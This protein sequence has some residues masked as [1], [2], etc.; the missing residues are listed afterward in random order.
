MKRLNVPF[1]EDLEKEDFHTLALNMETGAAKGYIDTICWPDDYPYAPDAVFSI[2]RSRTHLVIQYR[3]TGLDLRAK[4]LDDNGPVWEDSCC[5]FFVS[6]PADSTYYN[7]EMNC[8]GTLLASK[9]KSREEFE[10]FAGKAPLYFFS[11]KAK[12]LYWD[13][14]MEPGAFLVFG[15]ESHGLPQELHDRFHD[16]FYTLPMPGNFNR[17]LNLANSVAVTVYEGLRRKFTSPGA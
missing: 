1:L 4:A 2:A 17:S 15:S 14:P 10:R 8:I 5:E 6:D 11:T 16:F 13:C 12:K 3:V 7:F 9:R